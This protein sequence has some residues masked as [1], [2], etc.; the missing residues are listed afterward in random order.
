[1]SA[2]P[3]KEILWALVFAG[4]IALIFRFTR[5]L[6]AVTG[7]SDSVPWG[8]WKVLNM[9]AGVALSTG[10][11][12]FAAAVHVFQIRRLRPLLRTALL[13]AAMGYG[14]SCFALFVDIGLS[15]RIWHPL[16]HW[17]AHSFLF[18]VAWCVMLYL[19]I[20]LLEVTP[21]TLEES[22]HSRIKRIL[23]AIAPTVVII[24]ITLSTLHHTSLGSLF[25]V[26]PSRLHPLW[27]TPGLPIH[28][29]LSAIG[30]G[31][32]A[33]IL[34]VLLV[35]RLYRRRVPEQALGLAGKVAAVVLTLY[36]GTKVVDLWRRE[37]FSLLG[38]GDVES[39][40]YL[41]EVLLGVVLPLVLFALPRTR[42][43]PRGLGVA[44]GC[45]VAGVVLNRLD[46]GIL[47]YLSSA[48]GSY[49]PTAPELAICFGIPAAAGLVFFALVE[50][51]RFYSDGGPSA[52]LGP[53]PGAEGTVAG[54]R[55]RPVAARL[56]RTFVITLSVAI[57]LFTAT[58]GGAHP[59]P[60]RVQPPATLEPAAGSLRIDG[61][62]DGDAVTFPHA[63]H[64]EFLDCRSCHHMN[65]VDGEPVSCSR[66]HARLHDHA[67][68]F[69][70]GRHLV[71]VGEWRG[72]TGPRASN[73]TCV[74]CHD[75]G[76][77]RL[78]LAPDVCVRCH[79]EPGWEKTSGSDQTLSYTHALHALCIRCHG[80]R[81]EGTIRRAMGNC[82]FCHQ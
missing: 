10:G 30:S 28:F 43:S 45:C 5:G 39:L 55:L 13:L 16:V 35:G 77:P 21:I 47:G 61:D 54:F 73:R 80:E 26:S 82:T 31:I 37:A 27:Y 53:A 3:L 44:A 56:G 63:V 4:F 69:E 7:L 11:F 12:V 59:R 58:S 1:M 72:F 76:R 17:N 66:C 8:I 67:P 14:S 74:L 79:R 40:L 25:L 62:R 68:L 22:R 6:G 71:S 33:V 20:T 36:L 2:R 34:L 52:P 23:H 24:G 57:G 41:V 70:H 48:G 9:V 38:A 64:S 51:F 46:V 60:G 18:E 19:S 75:E 50:R 32:S 42:R 78:D 15:W 49:L 81:Q 29:I 65:A